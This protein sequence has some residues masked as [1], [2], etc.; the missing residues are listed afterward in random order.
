MIILNL[1][2]RVLLA[3]KDDVVRNDIIKEYT[4]YISSCAK[5]IVG[6]YVSKEDDEMSVAMIAFDEAITKYDSAK[7]SFL[8][9]AN[10]VIRNRLID[11]IRKDNKHSKTIPF[12]E[13]SQTDK[14]GR[15]IAF[16]IEDKK[17]NIGDVKYEL[18]AL[19]TELSKYDICFS[20]LPKVSPKSKKTKEACFK[21]IKYIIQNPVLVNE[22][23]LKGLIPIKNILSSV[24]IH[25]KV[26]ERHR[27]YI[28]TAI[29]ILTGE[30]YIVAEYFNDL[31]EVAG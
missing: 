27:K 19:A 1:E 30:Y 9:F 15:E 12:S 2:E 6:R 23:K 31:K 29:I 11:F 3:Q 24:K 25:R 4:N 16:D 18:K 21:I 22:I 5:N 7:G 28:I 10:I 20:D 14:D 13:L 26:I 17:D 8:N